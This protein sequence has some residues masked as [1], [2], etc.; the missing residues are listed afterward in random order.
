M[1]IY[2]YSLLISFFIIINFKY[3]QRAQIDALFDHY[4]TQPL[5]TGLETLEDTFDKSDPNKMHKLQFLKFLLDSGM[6]KDDCF[7]TSKPLF[8]I[9][10]FMK[11]NY[12]LLKEFGGG[13]NPGGSN[14]A[15]EPPKPKKSL[16]SLCLKK[17]K[18]KAR[19]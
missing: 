2:I 5:I 10:K 17:T 15:S 4:R 6:S 9:F 14:P 11:H 16:L 18:E 7:D 12:S 19:R 1:Y 3:F 8:T 13:G